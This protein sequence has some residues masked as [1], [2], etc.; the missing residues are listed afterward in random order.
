MDTE[1]HDLAMHEKLELHELLAFKSLCLTKA[2]AMQKL[3]SDENLKLILQKDAE[4]AERHV[5][6]LQETLS[7]HVVS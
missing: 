1:A 7:Q 2:K 5:R 6:Q 3:V 4:T